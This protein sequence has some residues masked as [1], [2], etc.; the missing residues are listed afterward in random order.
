MMNTGLTC[1]LYSH[2]SVV[3]HRHST[4]L[5]VDIGVREPWFADVIASPPQLTETRPVNGTVVALAPGHL[6][7]RC[8]VPPYVKAIS[9]V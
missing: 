3:R 4:E 9:D 7:L 8:I 2:A 6:R 1:P 5:V